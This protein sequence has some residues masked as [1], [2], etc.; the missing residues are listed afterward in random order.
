MKKEVIL[1]VIIL[2]ILISFQESF[3]GKVVSVGECLLM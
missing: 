2:L 1:V 3:T